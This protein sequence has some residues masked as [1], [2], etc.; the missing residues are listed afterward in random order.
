MN[1]EQGEVWL[2][3]FF[4]K[5]GSEISKIRPAIV[6]SHNEIGRLPLKTI[7]PVTDWKTKYAHYPW[8]IQ[9][10]DT[11]INGLTKISAIDCFQ[12]KNFAN[13][14]FMEK[15]GVVNNKMIKQIHTTIVKCFDPNYNLS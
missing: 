5:V 12:V 11:N 7:V 8:M 3:K 1:I 4:P 10:T 15:S 14:R 13:E 9:I 6:V 2:V